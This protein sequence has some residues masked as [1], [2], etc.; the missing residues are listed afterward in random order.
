MSRLLVGWMGGTDFS[1]RPERPL[2]GVRTNTRRSADLT[3]TARRGVELTTTFTTMSDQLSLGSSKQPAA[4]LHQISS[5]S[6]FGKETTKLMKKNFSL[7]LLR[8]RKSCLTFPSDALS[9]SFSRSPSL[10]SL[11]PSCS[12]DRKLA[13]KKLIPGLCFFRG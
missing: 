3:S 12:V 8:R 13:K 10:L 1:S 6:S 7:L 4:K 2:L 5:S 9:L 11:L